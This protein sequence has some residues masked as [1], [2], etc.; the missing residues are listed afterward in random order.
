MKRQR[1]LLVCLGNICRSPLAEVIIRQQAKAMGLEND[2]SFA[3]AGT[4]DWHIG[5]P[6]DRRSAE[7]AARHGLSLEHH[8]AQQITPA[9]MNRWDWFIAMDQANASDLLRMGVNSQR[10]LLMRQFEAEGGG[11]VP[12]PYYGSPQGFEH[13]YQLLADNARTMLAFLEQHR[14]DPQ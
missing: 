1:V 8:R 4:G 13:V 9:N 6:A 10:L 14:E 12:D 5:Q 11:D 7:V 2:F 3:S